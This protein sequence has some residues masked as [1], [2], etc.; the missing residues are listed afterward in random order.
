M[1]KK[2]TKYDVVGLGVSTVDL[3]MLVDEFP[4]QEMVQRAHDSTLA[5][6][7]PVATAMVALAR[8]G[9][10]TAMA[11]K[12]G[13]DWRGRL[14]VEE[15]QREGVAT[16]L[17]AIAEASSSIASI[18][19]RKR[20]GARTIVYAPGDVGEML[21]AEISHDALAASIL[22]LNGRHLESCL[23]LAERA[24]KD[25]VLVSFDGGAHR[26]RSELDELLK[27]TDICIVAREFAASFSGQPEEVAASAASLM[28]AGS[29]IVVITGG[30]DGCWVFRKGEAA[31]HQP[32]FLMPSVV[33]TTGAGDAFHGGFLFG[34][35]RGW[36]LP[37]CAVV[38]SAVAALSTQKLGG[39][40]GLP[41]LSEVRAFLFSRG[42][43]SLPL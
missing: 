2:G 42:P 36:T 24:K 38:A 21:P 4:D 19:V 5:G 9:A 25:G 22:H 34:M 1:I 27:L 28:D 8:L 43:Y 33:D 16:D 30:T 7:G 13:D 32:A 15:F 41:S 31:F 18:L 35:L 39:R 17:L 37:D 11:D 26:Y 29:Q 23:F 20:D 10:R 14:I 40:A 3:L 12:L 6:G